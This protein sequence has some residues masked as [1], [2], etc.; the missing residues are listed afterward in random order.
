MAVK[1][2]FVTGATGFLGQHLC[3]ALKDRCEVVVGL[4]RDRVPSRTFEGVAVAGDLADVA[5]IERVLAEYEIDTVF[6]LAAQTQVSTAE[7]DPAGTIAANV[8]G[9]ANVLEACRRQGVRRVVVASSDKC[10]GDGP[11]PYRESQPLRAHGVYA[12]SK[13]C[14]DLLAQSYARDFGMSVA[15][16]RCANLYGPGHE[17]YS[18]LIPGT[19]REALAGR[20][21][22]IRSDGSPRRDFL[23]VS[24]AVRGYLAL[25]ESTEVGAY[26]FGTGSP[27][28]VLEVVREVLA[29]VG[30]DIP[31]IVLGGAKGEIKDQ[32]L[33]SSR[34]LVDLDWEALISLKNGLTD[35]VLWYRAQRDKR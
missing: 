24:D 15:V 23:H 10:Y 21:P 30:L 19:I 17:N 16:T 28:T 9:T 32:W 29:A 13:A 27:H 5:L 18:T 2:A 14:G 6:H 7:A 33:D 26:N 8:V 1:R 34:A 22:I 35:T 4:E 20:N 11:V 31:P 12:T 25:A 3:R